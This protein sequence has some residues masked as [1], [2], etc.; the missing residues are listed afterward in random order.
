MPIDVT[1][2]ENA[3]ISGQP[4]EA[5]APEKTESVSP[6]PSPPSEPPAP[7]GNVNPQGEVSKPDIG[8]APIKA[9]AGGPEQTK[10]RE[11]GGP[12]PGSSTSSPADRTGSQS[13]NDQNGTEQENPKYIG[14][15]LPESPGRD[16]QGTE[17]S[18]SPAELNLKLEVDPIVERESS[19]GEQ[20]EQPSSR[21]EAGPEAKEDGTQS[22]TK[23]PPISDSPAPIH[24][25]NKA[26]VEKSA[27]KPIARSKPSS[28]EGNA[29]PVSLTDERLDAS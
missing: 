13:L 28:G 19:P 3:F 12:A 15:R 22:N 20:S 1:Q 24:E 6:G 23:D 8:E 21:S 27:P 10:Q 16:D 9:D 14:Q 25:V 29:S 11:A 5:A 2:Y 18:Q 17:P 4:S 7:L 26:K